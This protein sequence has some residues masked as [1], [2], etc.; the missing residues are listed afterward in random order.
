MAAGRVGDSDVAGPRLKGIVE[1]TGKSY[2]TTEVT[3]M[4][5][6]SLMGY[7]QVLSMEGEQRGKQ[8]GKLEGR[9]EGRLEILNL[10]KAGC[11]TEALRERLE[12]ELA[13]AESESRTR[14]SQL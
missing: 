2:R 7:G 4:I 6:T 11:S 1:Y 14:P 13:S 9:L 3:E 8:R 10:L 12:A 5:D